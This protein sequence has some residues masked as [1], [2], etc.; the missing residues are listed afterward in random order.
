MRKM[1]KKILAFVLAGAMTLSM[2]SVSMP[3]VAA[4]GSGSATNS[5]LKKVSVEKTMDGTFFSATGFAA[6]NVNDRSAYKEGDAEYAVVTDEYSFFE[7]ISG[8][9]NGEIKVIELRSDLNLGWNELSED[10]K[11]DWSDFIQPFKDSEN[12]AGV[13][14]GNPVLIETGISDV[15][16]NMIDGLTVFSQDGSTIKHAQIILESEVNDFIIRNIKIDEVWEWD[17]WRPSGY[18]ST[19]G[20]GNHKRTGW[21]CMKLNGC[22]NVWIDHCSF[23]LGF[24][25]CL[26]MENG[27]EGISITWCEFGDLD[28]SKGSMIYR[29]AMYLEE[30]YQ[31]SKVDKDVESF[32]MYGIMRDNGMSVQD[33]MDYM[34]YHSKCHLVGA[35]DKDTWLIP[36]EDENGEFKYDYSDGKKYTQAEVD[37]GL[38]SYVGEQFPTTLT[39]V[40]YEKTDANELIEMTM[41]YNQYYNMGQRVP[42]IRGGVGHMFNCYV[43][44]EMSERTNAML[45]RRNEAGKTI[46]SLIGEAKGTASKLERCINARNGASIAADTCVWDNVSQPVIGSE[47][48]KNDTA[49]MNAPYHTYFTYNYSLVVNSSVKRSSTSETYVGN[50]Y[51]NDGDNEFTKGMEW[52]DKSTIKEGGFSWSNLAIKNAYRAEGI[53][54]KAVALAN[55]DKLTY[56]YQTFPLEEVQTNTDKYSGAYQVVMTAEDWLKTTYDASFTAKTVEEVGAVVEATGVAISQETANIFIDEDEYLQLTA[57]ILPYN[58]TVSQGAVEWSSSDETVAKVLDA[59]LVIPQNYGKAT[60]TAK[61]GNFTASCEVSVEKSIKSLEIVDVPETVYTGDIFK[62]NVKITPEDVM[63]DTVLWDSLSTRY[64]VLDVNNGVVQALKAGKGG[65]QATSNLKGNRLDSTATMVSKN[66]TAVDPAVPVTGVAMAQDV[67]TIELDS[68]GVAVATGAAVAN[69]LPAD[70]TNQ[71]VY[72]SVSDENIATIDE[73]GVITPVT[74]GSVVVTA[75]TMNY[76]YEATCAA[77]ITGKA[78]D[79]PTPPTPPVNDVTPGDVNLDGDVTLDDANLALK[80]ALGIGADLTGDALVAANVNLV[81]GVTLDDANMILK[82]ALG[83]PVD[84]PK[85]K[86]TEMLGL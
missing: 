41:A 12:L 56:D 78:V 9:Q 14:V 13:P 66:I 4:T 37:R 5:W 80:A 22:K 57:T 71:K 48:Q 68:S 73:N 31:Q 7:A 46:S 79:V 67:V 34:C 20:K 60:I 15:K 33:V 69:V 6:A 58:A 21:A 32:V 26:D 44:D 86:L 45:Q 40:D 51:D 3:T 75:K 42:M 16:I 63:D 23:G 70:A 30:I 76:G 77:V 28:T 39:T 29:T 38:G 85:A 2:T 52:Y 27:A 64:K 72:W 11:N 83:I 47:Y 62:L 10:V 50:S 59:G 74:K 43:N 18:G 54:D 19:G 1:A 82:L 61:L 81:D 36:V 49:N 17:D 53:T 24:D 55:Y 84:L 8:A 35:G 25:G 65:I